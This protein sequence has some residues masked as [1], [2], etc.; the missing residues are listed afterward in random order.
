MKPTVLLSL[1]LALCSMA[2]HAQQTKSTQFVAANLFK[3]HDAKFQIT[4]DTSSAIP[5]FTYQDTAQKLEFSGDQIRRVENGELGTLVS[6]FTRRTVDSGS[7]T[8]TL[9][10]PHVN[11]TSDA[12]TDVRTYGIIVVHRFSVIQKQNQGEIETYMAY[13]LVG[14]AEHAAPQ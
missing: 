7:T 6:V 1:F 14:T 5:H 11:L 4:Y 8:F 9:L 13:D 10:V 2:V 3:V 12:P